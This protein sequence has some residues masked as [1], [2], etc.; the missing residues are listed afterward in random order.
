MGK[1]CERN[2]EEQYLGLMSGDLTKYD[3]QV[4]TK[5]DSLVKR[6]GGQCNH[7]T[8][9]HCLIS[10]CQYCRLPFDGNHLNPFSA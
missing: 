5:C 4:C 7:F 6:K 9:E 2:L 1:S 3:Y 8:C 10:F